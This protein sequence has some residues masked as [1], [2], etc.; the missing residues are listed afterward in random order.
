MPA[1]L[2]IKLNAD[3][4]IDA[5][6]EIRVEAT[7]SLHSVMSGVLLQV[8]EAGFQNS[9][10]LPA[11]NIPEQIR[12]N[13][14]NLIHQPLSKVEL[15]GGFNLLIG[16]Q[17]LALTAPI[18]YVGG[19]KFKQKAQ[20]IITLL[21]SLPII[22]SVNRLSIKYTDF[23][24]ASSL[25]QLDNYLNLDIKLGS[26]DIPETQA[27]DLNF[28]VKGQQGILHLLRLVALTRLEDD[29]EGLILEVDTIKQLN[30]LSA[31][32][33]QPIIASTLDLIHQQSKKQFFS[34]L[35]QQALDKLGAIYE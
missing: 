28:Q 15:E 18:P 29:Q 9:L 31:E 35:N 2:P 22:K 13:D 30:K 1:I 6:I 12:K 20:Q 10:E 33:F 4:I 26:I 3:P 27:Y 17:I 24:E 32:E 7:Q 16:D 19:I 5:V 8:K 11:A 23:I 34:L 14:P 21:L 25:Q